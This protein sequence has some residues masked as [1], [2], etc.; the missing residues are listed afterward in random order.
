M[1]QAKAQAQLRAQVKKNP[2]QLREFASSRATQVQHQ[3]QPKIASK[4]SNLQLQAAS[5]TTHLKPEEAA[6]CRSFPAAAAYAVIALLA[7]PD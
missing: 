7:P 4:E 5:G 1:K 6:C 2:C 3:Q